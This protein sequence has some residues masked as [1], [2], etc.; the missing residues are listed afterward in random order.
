[1]SLPWPTFTTWHR[2]AEEDRAA[3]SSVITQLLAHGALLGE[4]GRNR[5]LYLLAR[6]YQ[7]EI[8]EY[9]APLN[10]ELVA[11]PDKPIFHARPIPADCGLMARFNKAETLLVLTLWRMFH[12]AR[13]ASVAET[14]I[15]TANDVWRQLGLH[16]P[17]D[18]PSE[19]HLREMLNRL[20]GRRLVRIQSPDD[21]SR[22]GDT[23]IEILP[24]LPRVIPF[25][26]AAAWEEQA[27]LYRQPGEETP[28]QESL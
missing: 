14:V 20:R 8:A 23:Q 3:V 6:E 22:F 10:I 24:T 16:F 11:D 21:P 7:T 9:L 25:E 4:E 28:E 19:S 13:M 15:V 27:A 12:D 26:D 1:M 17:I 2:I 18:P 5:E